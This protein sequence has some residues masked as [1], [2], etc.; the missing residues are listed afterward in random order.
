MLRTGDTPWKRFYSQP[1]SPPPLPFPQPELTQRRRQ[2]G[3][4]QIAATR[5]QPSAAALRFVEPAPGGFV[6]QGPTAAKIVGMSPKGTAFSVH[7]FI[8]V[9]RTE[10]R[11]CL[12]CLVSRIGRHS[13]AH[14]QP[15]DRP[16]TRP[17]DAATSRRPRAAVAAFHLA[18]NGADKRDRS[19][20]SGDRAWGG[21]GLKPVLFRG[22]LGH[23][24]PAR[25]PII[26]RVPRHC[27]RLTPASPHHPRHALLRPSRDGP[28]GN[29]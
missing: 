7:R 3:K 9:R 26:S 27:R 2:I 4:A 28:G 21:V 15:I 1:L 17:Q 14:K 22:W 19:I 24:V 5:T 13:D 25:A 18:T 20:A 12:E 10:N 8:R 6:D 23:N 11:R 16:A 29:H